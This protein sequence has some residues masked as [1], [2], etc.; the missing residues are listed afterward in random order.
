M[1]VKGEGNIRMSFA[2]EGRRLSAKYG[3]LFF[4]L[5]NPVP[6]HD[7]WMYNVD[8]RSLAVVTGINWFQ[9]CNNIHRRIN[10]DGVNQNHLFELN[11]PTLRLVFSFL[12]V[13]QQE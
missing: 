11:K 7:R 6:V 12:E 1:F 4:D 9:S 8:A 2:G 3:T 5:T 10:K 13:V